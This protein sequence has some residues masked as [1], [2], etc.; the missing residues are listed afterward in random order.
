MIIRHYSKHK[1]A[2]KMNLGKGI[3]IVMLVKGT[4]TF[5]VIVQSYNESVQNVSLL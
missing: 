4:L 3:S 1:A 2:T 5:K